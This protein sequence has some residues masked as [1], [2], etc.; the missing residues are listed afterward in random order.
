MI[1]FSHVSKLFGAQK[2]V[3]DL[4]LN[5]QEGSFSVLI[6]TSGSGKSTTLKMINRL[7]EHDS[8][9][10][11][12]AGEEIR[13]LPVLELRR[14]MGYAI[15]SIGLFP[16]WS[17]AQNIATVP[18]LQ[19]WSRARI[20][21]RIDELMALLGLEPNLRE[22]YPHQ[23][24]GGQQQRV[25]VARALAADPQV[26][27]MDEPFG[28]LDPVTR[29]ALQQEMT[30]IHRLQGRTIVLVTHDIDEALRL[31][32]H[33]VLMDHGEVVQQGNP[34]AMLTHPANDFVRQFFGR[35]EL[36]VR[37]LS[38]RSVAD[39]V[40]REERA[41]GEALEERMTLRDALSLFVARGCE[42]LP[43]VNT[44]GQPLFAALFPQL[45]RPVYQ[46]E[47]FAALALAH[48]WLV[49]ISSL[50]AVII[51]TGAGIAVTRP[52]GAEFRPLVETIAAV[53]QTFPPVAVLAIAVPVI[54]FGLKPAI[55]A[56]ILYG[57]LPVLQATLAG[58]GAIDASV[59]E[60]AKGMGMSRG[61]RLR[62]VELPLAAPVILAGVRTSVIINI[63]TATIASTVG[64]STLGT[65]II[66]GLSG[67]NTAYVIQGAL[68]VALAAIIADRLFER[69]VQAF[70]QHAK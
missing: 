42:V 11:R 48:F 23:L 8:G 37:L 46:Q 41:E 64:A 31:A 56:L 6:G 29:G 15:Q 69:L 10:I 44:Q 68:L 4:N 14:R 36:G 49:G 59:T 17:V 27:L 33:L 25:G 20:D 9:V 22:R 28:A 66:I 67:F 63:G 50:F 13:S 60:V 18:Q 21:D 54:G 57:V 51:G 1:E 5:F 24:S 38:L 40:R 62:K 7:V 53:G 12:F 34:L 45:P 2:A 39:Y 47:S 58:L 26:L 19:K 61:Q 55:I 30:R 3:N 70:S 32:E 43:V 65:P 16:H 52:W 35:S